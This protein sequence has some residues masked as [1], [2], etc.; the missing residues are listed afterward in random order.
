MLKPTWLSYGELR[1][2]E[3]AFQRI[4]EYSP[5]SKIVDFFF[6]NYSEPVLDITFRDAIDQFLQAKVTANSRPLTIRNLRVRI[7]GLI[8]KYPQGTMLSAVQPKDIHK[9]VYRRGL[10]PS[11][12]NNERR[13]FRTFF[14]WAKRQGLIA[15]DPTDTVDP[16]KQGETEPEVLVLSDVRALLDATQ[17]VKAGVLVPSPCAYLRHSDRPRRSG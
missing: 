7:S 4:G 15:D 3:S 2:A 6:E 8:N 9:V 1:E 16:V 17:R 10:A 13:A 14:R 12:R 5:L 11:T